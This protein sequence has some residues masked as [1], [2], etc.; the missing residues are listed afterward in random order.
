M[1]VDVDGTVYIAFT[2][3]SS[4]KDRHGSVL[5]LVE[6]ITT[7]RSDEA[8]VNGVVAVADRMGKKPVVVGDRA[9]F[10]ANYL[11]FGY[12]TSEPVQRSVLKVNIWPNRYDGCIPA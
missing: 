5:K 12:F 6:V 10:V 2:N 1:E 8:V 4:V 11:L 3:N 9:G 7:V